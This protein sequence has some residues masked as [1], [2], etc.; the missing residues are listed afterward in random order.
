MSRPA[1]TYV[2]LDGR[3]NLPYGSVRVPMCRECFADYMTKH[4]ATTHTPVAREGIECAND[5]DALRDQPQA[6][7]EAK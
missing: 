7:Q 1:Y 5:H 2:W 3:Q 4:S 6:G